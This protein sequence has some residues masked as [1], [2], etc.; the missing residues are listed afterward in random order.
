M[1]FRNKLIRFFI[2][3]LL[4]IVLAY[5]AVDQG[6]RFRLQQ[7]LANK[8]AQG[9]LVNYEGLELKLFQGTA[10]FIQ[11][12]ILLS[13]ETNSG[14]TGNLSL[15]DIIIKDIGYVHLLLTG[16]LP[17][18]YIEMNGLDGQLIE[19]KQNEDAVNSTK[20]TKEEIGFVINLKE[21]I[22]TNTKLTVFNA[23]KK[24]ELL[25]LTDFNLTIKNILVSDKT[26]AKRFPFTGESYQIVS[27]PVFIKA[28]PFENITIDSINGTTNHTHVY[29]V[30][31]KTA[32]SKESFDAQLV[33]ERDHYS[34]QV[35]TILF[36]NLRLESINE[37]L[38]LKSNSITF[39]SPEVTIYRNK[40]IADD[41]SIKPLYG[42]LLREAPIGIAIDTFNLNAANIVYI[43]KSKPNNGGGELTFNALDATIT[44]LG[45]SY[46][47]PVQVHFKSKF[48]NA[49]PFV[50]DW[51]FDPNDQE[52]TF[53]FKGKLRDLDFT[54]VNAFT[55]PAAY[56][57]VE[58]Q[59]TDL[60]FTIYGHN[61]NST[62][63]LKIA[64]EDVSV[65][66]LHPDSYKRKKVLNTLLNLFMPNNTKNKGNRY[67][68]S[69]INVSR[70]KNKSPFN[71]LYKNIEK[72]LQD[73]IL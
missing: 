41:F 42:S 46:K 55:I 45:N 26:L 69:H 67:K 59:M 53:T 2:I 6:V 63:D 34:V 3:L 58:G 68:D 31:Y 65:Y 39:N 40:L 37:E 18:E 16:K 29:N 19:L 27:G 52:D 10:K 48:M 49:A 17:I 38:A 60:Y 44:N 5:F 50:A 61:D 47:T 28:T 71:Y 56:T 22:L 8:E 23:D 35:N 32:L 11:P 36:K 20:A 72:G 13:K 62:I 25:R 9:V 15:T 12:T 7:F 73:V 14:F 21:L 33:K 51:T 57:E 1:L 66:L 30:N 54:K 24:E 70:D 4:G 64:Y 43:E